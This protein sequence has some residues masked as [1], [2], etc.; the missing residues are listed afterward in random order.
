MLLTFF[1]ERYERRSVMI[2]SN[3]VFSQWERIFQDPMTAM[4]A[5]D[6]RYTTASFWSSAARGSACPK[7]KREE[8]Q[9]A[10]AIQPPPGRRPPIHKPVALGL[11]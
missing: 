9:P 6:R 10:D 4:A 3:L 1:A 5:V 11:A 2:S 8:N 7:T